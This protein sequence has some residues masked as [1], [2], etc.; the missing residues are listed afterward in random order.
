ME[1]KNLFNGTK[2]RLQSCPQPLFLGHTELCRSGLGW[3]RQS[4]RETRRG[5]GRG[6]KRKKERK[7]GGRRRGRGR[8]TWRLLEGHSTPVSIE[9]MANLLLWPS[10]SIAALRR[11]SKVLSPSL[12]LFFLSLPLS[13]SLSTF[14]TMSVW[15]LN[16]MARGC[17]ELCRQPTGPNIG[18]NI[19]NLAPKLIRCVNSTAVTYLPYF[20][21][22]K[23]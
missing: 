10:S 9:K 14:S 1:F 5:R 12:S 19:A 17:T 13:H 2:Q 4:K 3:L 18:T 8:E 15:A 6:R 22:S 21:W 20:C 7:R 16:G 23:S 11:P